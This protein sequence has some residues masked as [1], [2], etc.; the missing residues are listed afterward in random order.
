MQALVTGATG[1]IG[2]HVANLLI[3]NKFRVKCLVRKTGRLGDL[4]VQEAVQEVVG[5]LRDPVSLRQATADCDAV[6]HVAADY[7]LWAQNPAEMYDSNVQGTRNLLEAS[8]K[9]RRIV[10]TST[11]GCIGV[12]PGGIG[13]E[14]QPITLAEMSGHYKRSKFMAEQIALEKAR[15]GQPIVIVNPTAPVGEYDVKP[16][17]TGKIIV[18]YISRKMPAYIDTGLNFVDVHDVALGHWLAWEKGTVGERYILGR[19]NL[20]LSQLFDLLQ[21]ISGIPRPKTKMP[22]SVAYGAGWASTLWASVTGQPPRVPLDAVK[23]AKKKM[24]VNHAKAQ[25]QLGY[26]PRPIEEALTRAVDWFRQNGY[27]S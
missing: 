14:T 13:D 1:F 19:E 15:A 23:M 3:K 5:D 9:A 6:F 25:Q 24:F 8:E 7:R 2:R 26:Q 4:A 20:S 12:P 27:V 21:V 18:D 11:V 22:Y 16:T 17:E 10:Y